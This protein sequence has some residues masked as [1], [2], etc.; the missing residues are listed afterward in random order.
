MDK[1]EKLEITKEHHKIKTIT[2]FQKLEPQVRLYVLRLLKSQDI[3][4]KKYNWDEDKLGKILLA[5]ILQKLTSE[6]LLNMKSKKDMK[7]FNQLLLHL[8]KEGK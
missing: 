7:L 4:Y 8:Y 1:T 5:V 2:L 3:N 6:I